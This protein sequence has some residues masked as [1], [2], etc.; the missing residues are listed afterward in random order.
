[1]LQAQGI[2]DYL[3]RRLGL[4]K[5]GV[6]G[7]TTPSLA[8]SRAGFGLNGV[9]N[10]LSLDKD[11]N[12]VAGSGHGVEEQERV[13]EA[14][15]AKGRELSKKWRDL[16]AGCVSPLSSHTQ[17]FISCLLCTLSPLFFLS[18]YLSIYPFPPSFFHSQERLFDKVTIALVGKYTDL[19]DS[20]M[21]V[22]K[23][24][25]HSAFRV[26]RKLTIQVCFSKLF[27]SFLF[28][29]DSYGVLYACSP[30]HFLLRLSVYPMN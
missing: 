20:Y 14:R 13:W 23:A 5:L 27:F 25:E 18:I 19:K 11:V 9:V 4:D 3:I 21:S 16:T 24:L 29:F 7:Q 2:V 28:P 8:Q 22:T 1:M 12:I 17:S 10:G 26:H 6:D 15:R 30:S